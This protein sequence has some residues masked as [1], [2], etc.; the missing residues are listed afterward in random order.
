LNRC[1]AEILDDFIPIEDPTAGG[2]VDR[3]RPRYTGHGDI[4]VGVR[5]TK[6]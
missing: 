3:R 4:Y 2:H 6:L 5:E 1:A